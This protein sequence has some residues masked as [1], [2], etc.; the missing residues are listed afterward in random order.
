MLKHAASCFFTA[1]NFAKAATLF[2]HLKQFGQAAECHLMTGQ[3]TKAAHL[4]EQ[5]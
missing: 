5:A 4:Y 2:E 3:L 1:K